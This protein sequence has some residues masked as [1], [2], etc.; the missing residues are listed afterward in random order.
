MPAKPATPYDEYALAVSAYTDAGAQETVQ[1]VVTAINRLERRLDVFYREQF[2]ELDVAH[3]E[4]AVLSNLAIEAR[5]GGSTP[6]QLADVCGVSPSTMTHRLDRMVERGLVERSPDP[7][8]RTR[9]RV[10]LA[11]GGWELFQRAVLDAEVVESRVLSPLSADERRQL[12]GL[13]EKVVA[14]MRVH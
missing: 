12:A 9:I 11:R 7:D 5:E 1:R 13:L 4:W 2:D 14:G 8:N 6:T 10:T 3:G